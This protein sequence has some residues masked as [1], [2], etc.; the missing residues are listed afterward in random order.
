MGQ[1]DDK[2]RIEAEAAEWVIRLGGEPLSPEERQ[3]FEGWRA[4]STSHA[5]AFE[6]A[7]QTW[8]DL[9][10]LRRA[11]GSLVAD[12]AS[13]RLP[14]RA[15]QPVPGAAVMAKRR[16]GFWRHGVALAI[17]LTAAVGAGSFW[18][19]NPATLIASDYHTAPGEQRT[20]DLPDGSVVEL[21][22]G[23]AIAL[24]FNET[25]RRVTLIEGAA[26]FT[27]VPIG[28]TEKR[29]FV[30]EGADGTA[31]ALGTQFAVAR[32]PDAVEVTVAEHDVRVALSDAA[33]G[34][35]QVVLSPGQSV[36]YSPAAGLGKVSVRDV[37]QAT[38]WRRG[39]LIFDQVPLAE[40][41]TELNRYRRGRIV[42]TGSMLANRKVS[43]VFRI[44][45]LDNALHTIASELGLRSASVP[46][47]IT[48]LY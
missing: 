18:Y 21:S 23:S 27:A 41:V 34:A 9:A 43:G 48:V 29:P 4:R 5:Q 33:D 31:T 1:R 26:Y 28:P 38:A 15:Y 8:S 25:E 47:L 30:V 13:A 22:T 32:L 39:R 40:V 36:R 19:G 37:E 35:I 17:C 2:E 6:F 20:V 16:S 3:S 7:R 10:A 46:P 12:I 45:D 24:R 44:D 11:P 42:I 14:Q